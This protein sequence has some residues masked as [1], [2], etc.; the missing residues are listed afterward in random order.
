M[1]KPITQCDC[2]PNF[3]ITWKRSKGQGI[4]EEDFIEEEI[5]RKNGR[6]RA[7]SIRY[8]KPYTQVLRKIDLAKIRL[9][10]F[11]TN[12]WLRYNSGYKI[13]P[14]PRN[15]RFIRSCLICISNIYSSHSQGQNVE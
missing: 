3:L 4:T 9:W 13:Q 11:E 1:L 5:E 2:I 8:N 6:N 15:L 12:S 14:V 7:Q 10:I